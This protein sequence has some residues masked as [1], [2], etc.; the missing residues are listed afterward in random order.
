[1]DSHRTVND[2]N[3]I[4]DNE[5]RDSSDG[6]DGSDASVRT[7]CGRVTPTRTG[8]EPLNVDTPALLVRARE[9]G[10]L[11]KRTGDLLTVRGPKRLA[12]LAELLLARK[13]EVLALIDAEQ[14]TRS[15]T[16]PVAESVGEFN[17]NQSA[18]HGALAYRGELARWPIPWRQRWGELANELED[19]D[20]RFPESEREAF[21]R[22]KAQMGEYETLSGTNRHEEPRP[23][24]L[25][26][27]RRHRPA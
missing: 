23:P 21:R 26:D 5:L 12:H 8:M 4:G 1:M 20:L 14:A 25:S 13:P 15:R 7:H 17:G 10:L 19:Q 2:A 6:R 24:L 16:T 22:I 18:R 9:A 3:V 27:G 11:V